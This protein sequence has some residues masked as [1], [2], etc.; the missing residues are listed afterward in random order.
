MRARSVLGKVK[1]K[2]MFIYLSLKA[3]VTPQIFFVTLLLSL[4]TSGVC[5]EQP[6]KSPVE[7]ERP[8]PMKPSSDWNAQFTLGYLPSAELRGLNASAAISDYCIRLNRNFRLDSS[9]TLT[10]GG[11]YALK[12]IDAPA[13][14]GLPQD[15]HSLTLETGVNYRISERSFAS[16]RITPGFYSDFG[17]IGSDDVK[18]PVLALGGYSFDNGLTLVGGFVYRV[19]YHS[20]P[21]FPVIGLTYQPNPQWIFELVAPRPGLKY[22]PS[23]YFR[24]F[25]TG[26]FASDEYELKD[27]S[28]GAKAMKYRDYKLMGG[29]EYLPVSDTRLTGA[30]GYA[31]DRSFEFYDGTRGNMRMDDAPFIKFSLDVGW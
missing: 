14:A 18:M 8:V 10:V 25:L 30:L 15:L 28:S 6:G 17:N 2:N 7:K 26:D 13:G 27:R 29:V 20:T 21:F 4:C 12:Q 23:R 22:I 3:K 5:A 31:F 16:L 24:L 1:G 9:T 11:A 19:G